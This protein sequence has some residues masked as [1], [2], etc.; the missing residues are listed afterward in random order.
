M[1]LETPCDLGELLVG[2]AGFE[3]AASSSRSQVRIPTASTVACLTLE[4]LSVSVRW[5]P[6]LP[7]AVVTH[8]VTRPAREQHPPAPSLACDGTSPRVTVRPFVAGSNCTLIT[9]R[10]IRGLCPANRTDGSGEGLEVGA[11]LFRAKG[12]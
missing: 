7:V 3:P 2:V 1:T 9:R 6:P 5:C 4:R 8:L 10:S 11:I 12:L